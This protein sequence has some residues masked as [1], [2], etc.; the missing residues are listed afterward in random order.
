MSKILV[1]YFS[2]AGDNYAVGVISEGNT[3][4]MSQ[5]I[6][7]YLKADLFEIKGTNTYPEKYKDC[8][9]Q[10]KKEQASKFRPDLAQKCAKISDYDTVF[11]GYPIWWSDYP[12]AVYSFIETHDLKGKKVI[13]FCTHE[14]GGESGTFSRLK[15]L[16]PEST[17]VVDGLAPQG[18]F[19]REELN[20][21]PVE[22]WLKKLGY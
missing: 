9:D 17:V 6:A 11:L 7:D 3:K 21:K 22:A 13:P 19:A 4:I 12:M 10:A 20:R 2:K 1:A 18:V 8:C 15:T 16:L 14:G 5:Q